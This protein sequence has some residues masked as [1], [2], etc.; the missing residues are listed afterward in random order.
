MIDQLR[1]N[2]LGNSQSINYSDR[3]SAHEIFNRLHRHNFLDNSPL[4][5]FMSLDACI[6][7]IIWFTNFLLLFFKPLEILF[8]NRII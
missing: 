4:D 7:K 6:P 5:N 3:G 8:P 1:H 2:F